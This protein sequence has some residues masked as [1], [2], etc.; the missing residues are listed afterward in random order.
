MIKQIVTKIRLIREMR[1]S[2]SYLKHR[3][4]HKQAELLEKCI[5]NLKLS[6]QKR[7]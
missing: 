4:N 5:E 3:G 7:I 2:L 6:L 1:K